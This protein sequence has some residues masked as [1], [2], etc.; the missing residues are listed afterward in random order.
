[1]DHDAQSTSR[2]PTLVGIA[3]IVGLMLVVTIAGVRT[4]FNEQNDSNL[5]SIR[6]TTAA[7]GICAGFATDTLAT[8]PDATE[9]TNLDRATA[10]TDGVQRITARID[11]QGIANGPPDGENTFV[12]VMESRDG[13]WEVVDWWPE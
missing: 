2:I 6:D 13:T 7:V 5:P 8:P 9:A 3:A 4:Y 11:L 1:M 10:S 12:C